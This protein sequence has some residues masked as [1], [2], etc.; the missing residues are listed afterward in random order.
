MATLPLAAKQ[1]EAA[2]TAKHS[3]EKAHNTSRGISSKKGSR[4]DSLTIVIKLGTSS[5]CD[6][7]THFPLLSTLSLI[8]E[9]ILKLKALGHR[10]VLV[11]SGAIGVGL[12]RMN[13]AS[14]PKEL[15]QIQAVAAVGQGRLMSLYDDLFSQFNQPIAQIL[16][17]KNDLADRTQYLN[18]C[19]TLNA[20]LDMGVVPIVNENDTISVSEIRFGDNDTLSAITAGMIHADYLFLMTD[21]DC[22]YT[23]NPRT[24]PDAKPVLV[25]DDIAA[26][27]EKVSVASA[28]SSLGTGGMVTKLIAA[29]LATAAGVTTVITRGSTPQRIFQII[30]QPI[31]RGGRASPKPAS[32]TS[33]ASGP[34]AGTATGAAESAIPLHTRFIAKD[35][36]M[37]DRKWWILHGLHTAGTIYIDR[38]AYKTI[39][40]ATQKSS[41]FAAGIVN[42]KGTFVAQQSVRVVYRPRD[43]IKK[44][45]QGI[46][47]EEIDPNEPEE[48]EVGKGL[49]NYASHEILRIMGCHSSQISERLGYAD[50]ECVIHRENLTRTKL[51]KP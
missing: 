47:L 37:V 28:G 51:T 20:L 36:P 44:D 15:A 4:G 9:T 13:L 16:L 8:I 24:N 23:D 11:T 33:S 40:K 27:K 50:A 21:V 14:K 35:N 32:S 49:V 48:I 30:S 43:F 1:A 45:E 6:E 17:T 26:L 18:A 31:Q 22:L 5:I 19:N 42:C 41:L 39:T 2:A 12:R 38:G 34:E 7:V 46:A 10:V 3:H 25:V 29:E